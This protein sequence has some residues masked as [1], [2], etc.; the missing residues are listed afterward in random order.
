MATNKKKRPAD[1]NQLAASIVADATDPGEAPQETTPEEPTNDGKNPHAVAL[2]RE[3]GLKGGKAR[4][5]KLTPEQRKEI[6][7]K[8]ARARWDKN[9]EKT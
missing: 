6:A 1:I 5:A 4:A 8:A 3:G 9:Q 7:Q 2:G